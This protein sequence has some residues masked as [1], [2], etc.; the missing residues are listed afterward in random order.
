[1]AEFKNA[2]P[3]P[4]SDQEITAVYQ[5]AVR[6]ARENDILGWRNL[7][8]RFPSWIEV[9]LTKWRDRTA[10]G[11]LKDFKEVYKAV[12]DAVAELGPLFAVALAGVES[13]QEKFRNQ[14]SL[15]DDLLNVYGWDR[16][17]SVA[18]A[19]LPRALGFVYQGLHGAICMSTGQ[20]E[21]ALE[22]VDNKIKT[23]YER[24]YRMV[25]EFRDIMGWPETLGG[26]CI[27][28][29][30]YLAGGSERWSWLEPIFGSPSDYQ[31]SLAAY[32]MM[33]NIHELAWCLARRA[34]A[35]KPLPEIMNLQVP[36]CFMEQT[37]ILGNAF[38]LLIHQQNSLEAIWET[39]RV[40]RKLLE[41]NWSAWLR[42]C[43]QWLA[44]VYQSY[45]RDSRDFP[46][47][48]FFKRIS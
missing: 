3:G 44:N 37:R 43:Q 30:R 4:M 25:W 11:G 13:Q 16:S 12:D 28:A 18:I 38:S 34:D 35:D 41:E 15:L 22:F 5:E 1:M 46:H 10:K 33:L 19:E 47:A 27:D 7:L 31:R 6:L 26:N 21:L 42:I 14:R 17:G 45:F 40:P 8:K 20:Y 2:K 39:A 36:L 32:Y 23:L 29:W 24:E 9:T 48:D